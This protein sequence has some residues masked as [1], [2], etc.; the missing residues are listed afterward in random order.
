MRKNTHHT[1]ALAAL[2]GQ[3]LHNPETEIS[4]APSSSAQQIPILQPCPTP[5]VIP[6][7][8]NNFLRQEN[9]QTWASAGELFAQCPAAAA[10][11]ENSR[12]RAHQESGHILCAAHD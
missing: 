7:A 11:A 5:L 4:S 8:A 6:T 3:S 9:A 1:A 2:T 12:M 10:I